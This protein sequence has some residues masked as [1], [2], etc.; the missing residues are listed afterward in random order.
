V[1]FVPLALFNMGVTIG[2]F[3]LS[4]FTNASPF[5][6]ETAD[7]LLV[8]CCICL[9][10]DRSPT[11]DLSPGPTPA[12]VCS[13]VGTEDRFSFVGKDDPV[14]AFPV[15]A[16]F[17]EAR[18]EAAVLTTSAGAVREGNVFERSS[19]LGVAIFDALILLGVGSPV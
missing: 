17:A 1:A 18:G 8:G 5:C 7:P 13:F 12:L 10:V 19:A 15:G 4:G 16:M 11:I 3:G 14:W 2:A 9:L 6:E